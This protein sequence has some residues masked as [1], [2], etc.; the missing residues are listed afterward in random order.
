[1][2]YISN[3]SLDLPINRKVFLFF[4]IYYNKIIEQN[5]AK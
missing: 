4:G 5:N 3:I 1:M 2:V